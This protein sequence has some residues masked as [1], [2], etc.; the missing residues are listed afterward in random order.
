MRKI[1]QENLLNI[2]NESELDLEVDYELDVNPN[3]LDQKGRNWLEE[4]FDDLGGNGSIP[5]LEK[6]KF[7]WKINRFLFLFDFDLHFNR[8]RLSTFRSDLYHEFSFSFVDSQRRLC[9]TF[10]K[11]CL[12]AGMQHRIWN[13]PPVAQQW[14][15]KSSAPGDF[16]ENGATGWKLQAY[17]DMQID[18]Q[19]R[20][21]G[22][23]LVR[24]SPY[25]TLMTGGSLKRLDQLLVNPTDEQR[26]MLLNWFMRKMA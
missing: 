14:F 16:S 1:L 19:T 15:G 10:E 13:G 23:K 21:H 12:K 4:A 8:Y 18:L 24:L 20:I 17:N 3:F 7:D 11:E 6:L 2:I 26:E 25:E 5:L 22:Y 9:R